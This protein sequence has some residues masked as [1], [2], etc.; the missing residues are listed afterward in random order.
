MNTDEFKHFKV[1]NDSTLKT[2]N[3]DELIEYI[4]MLYHNW[5]A[6]DESYN[7]VMEYARKLSDKVTPKRPKYEKAVVPSK[8]Y[9]YSCPVCSRML[10]VNCKPSNIKYCDECMQAIDWSE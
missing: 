4:H 9:V 8:A 7:N 5:Q 6:T 10:G 3:K 1:H 2:L